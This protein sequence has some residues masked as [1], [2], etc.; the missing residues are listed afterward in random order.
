M[1]VDP[2][3]GADALNYISICTGGA[4]LDLGVELAIPG[5]RAVCLVEREAF[6]CAHLVEAMR[7]GL[8]APAPIWTN[9]R[10]FAGRRWRGSVDGF[11]GGIPCQPHSQAGRRL[12]A[13]DE[14]DLWST[15]RR[16]IAQARP[17]WVLIENVPGML[18][19]KPGETPGAERVWRD[20]Q[21]MGFEVAGGLFEAPEVGATDERQ[22]IFILGVALGDPE[23][24]RRGE[25]RA[26]PSLRSGWNA[27]AG[28][29]R[30]GVGQAD[31]QGDDGWAG[32]R[33]AETGARAAGFRRRGLAGCGDQLADPGRAGL[34]LAEQP[35]QPGQPGQAERGIE[36]GSTAP[37]L[38]GAHVVDAGGGG[39]DGRP[40]GEVGRPIGGTAV[41]RPGGIPLWPPR[42][43]DA[44][45]WREA[46]DLWPAAQ[47]AVRGMAHGVAGRVDPL[48]LLGNGVKPLQAAYALRTLA[49][50]LA[51]RSLGA[52]RL[53]RLMGEQE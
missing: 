20:L 7:Q 45:G 6:A 18:S 11:I 29:G 3:S 53:V 40:E 34:S 52:A 23:G 8:L 12:G 47:P 24:Q 13:A 38:R 25:G 43:N 17:W 36:P 27:A 37:E 19:A 9:A 1:S 4:G 51:R 2:C 5:A 26:E 28:D 22:R 44:S 39:R 14:R 42:P 46:L 48:R 32:E 16:I 31:A 30:L 35:G 15:A 50:D 49:T 21:R 10:T 41:E 33:A